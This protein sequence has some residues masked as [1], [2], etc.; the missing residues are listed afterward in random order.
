[1]ARSRK[2][3]GGVSQHAKYQA[4]SFFS[5]PMAI[6]SWL[7]GNRNMTSWAILDS[8]VVVYLPRFIITYG[9]SLDKIARG[10]LNYRYLVIITIY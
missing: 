4:T 1:M 2:K 10:N 6:L 5:S 8:E 9:L 3:Y 7:H